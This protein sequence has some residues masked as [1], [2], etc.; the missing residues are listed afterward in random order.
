[1]GEAGVAVA[2][3]DALRGDDAVG[4]RT[5][6]LL[7]PPGGRGAPGAVDHEVAGV[8]RT[9]RRGA[10]AGA[11]VVQACVRV[12]SGARRGLDVTVPVQRG[13]L[14]P[15]PPL[16]RAVDRG[17]RGDLRGGGLVGLVVAGQA[18]GP[19]GAVAPAR[20]GAAPVPAHALVRAARGE[21]DDV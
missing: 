17:G 16:A 13:G 12:A 14:R 19:R 5:E 1:G 18:D 20:V 3:V 21:D 15:P 4:R 10:L 2:P 11:D 9:G 8:A 7:E 6:L